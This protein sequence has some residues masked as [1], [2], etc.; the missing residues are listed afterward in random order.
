MMA[1]TWTDVAAAISASVLR[2]TTDKQEASSAS[3]FTRTL[4]MNVRYEVSEL[5]PLSLCPEQVG[6]QHYG[7]VAG[8]HL[9]D[10]AVLSQFSQKLHQI[11]AAETPTALK[12]SS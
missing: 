1:T 8:S 5:L 11:P 2:T 9:I 4:I 6:P 3:D 7:D 12:S 10:L